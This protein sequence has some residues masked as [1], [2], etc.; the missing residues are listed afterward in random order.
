MV[1]NPGTPE[2]KHYLKTNMLPVKKGDIIRISTG[3]G[4][5]YG[6]PKERSREAIASDIENGY[7]TLEHAQ[8]LYCY[9]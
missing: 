2:E 7:L 5:G 3:G 8:K 1:V 6:D 9:Q 4:G